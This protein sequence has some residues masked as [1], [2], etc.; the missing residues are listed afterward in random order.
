[1]TLFSKEA[2]AIFGAY[3][4]VT[5]PAVVVAAALVL[6]AV[7]NAVPLLTLIPLMSGAYGRLLWLEFL[8]HQHRLARLWNA[9]RTQNGK[10][11]T[12]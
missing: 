1:M 7:H 10:G 5:M 8:E 6:Q 11:V 9:D 4:H 2:V 3:L 12:R